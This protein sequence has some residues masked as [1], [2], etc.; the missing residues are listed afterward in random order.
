MTGLYGAGNQ[1]QGFGF[2]AYMLGS[3]SHTPNCL[4]VLGSSEWNRE[5]E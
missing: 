2:D 4:P 3:L 1:T 5:N